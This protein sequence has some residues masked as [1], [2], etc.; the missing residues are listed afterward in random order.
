MLVAKQVADLITYFRALTGIVMVWLGFEMGGEGLPLVAWLLVLD[1]TGD[2]LDG[3][4]ARRS[5]RKYSTWIGDHD[6]Q[7]D[8]F[9]SLGLLVYLMLA[10]YVNLWLAAA[11]LLVWV[12]V[13]W[14][15]GVPPALGMLFQAPIYAWFIAIALSENLSIGCVPVLWIS[16]ALIL[17]WPRFPRQMIPEFLA[18]M[19]SVW[20]VLN[21][22][23]KR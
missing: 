10:G 12:W 13:F 11:Y 21:P 16:A 5:R 14:R 23:P 19:R 3:S 8:M 2:S 9:V 1:W 7:V 6:L 18:G 17:T 20:Q 15:L 4:L 22:P